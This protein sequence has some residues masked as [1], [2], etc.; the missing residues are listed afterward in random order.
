VDQDNMQAHM[1]AGDPKWVYYS[2]VDY[3]RWH[4]W[5]G[6]QREKNKDPTASKA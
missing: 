4:T 3:T 2:V 1:L 6:I 5:Q